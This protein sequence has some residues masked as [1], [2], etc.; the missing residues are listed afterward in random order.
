[1]STTR[2]A[3]TFAFQADPS[4][5]QTGVTL[6]VR[7][8]RFNA[9][10][11]GS[12]T[13]QLP[14]YIGSTA[15]GAISSSPFASRQV[16]VVRSGGGLS[17]GFAGLLIVGSVHLSEF[18]GVGTYTP[19]TGTERFV[20]VGSGN[21][22]WGGSNAAT[23]GTIT[24]ATATRIKGTIAATLQKVAGPVGTPPATVNLRFDIG[25]Q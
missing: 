14:D 5:D 16:I 23:S 18:T 13:L 6:T 9:N 3:G 20:G 8:G 21:T 25:V 22:T 17:L 15:E 10:V 19:G 24:S 11:T 4:P 7:D 12:G 1:V 2:I